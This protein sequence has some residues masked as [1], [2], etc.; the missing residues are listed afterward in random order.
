MHLRN[1]DCWSGSWSGSWDGDD[2]D[3]TSSNWPSSAIGSSPT[4]RQH[5][6]K[7]QSALRGAVLAD[8]ESL[9]S[10][11]NHGAVDVGADDRSLSVVDRGLSENVSR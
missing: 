7:G 9:P 3:E 2:D 11:E 6:R 1:P 8:I 4:W 5:A 10:A